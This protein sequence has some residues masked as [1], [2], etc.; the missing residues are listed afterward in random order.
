MPRE[1]IKSILI[2]ITIAILIV[3]RFMEHKNISIAIPVTLITDASMV[4]LIVLAL[5]KSNK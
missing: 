3:T 5:L 1:K 2:L 4:I